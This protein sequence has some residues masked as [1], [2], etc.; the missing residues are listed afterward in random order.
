[1]IAVAPRW[2]GRVA[3]AA[4]LLAVACGVGAAIAVPVVGAY[5][6]YDESIESLRHQHRKL[7][8]V[9]ATQASL[10]RQLARIEAQR[11]GDEYMLTGDSEALAG[12]E[13]QNL[14]KELVVRNGG[15]LD[16]TQVLEAQTEGVLE[17]ITIRARFST[18]VPSLKRTL[19]VFEAGKPALFVERIEIR[20]DTAAARQVVGGAARGMPLKVSMD[21][22]GYRP[23][24]GG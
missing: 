14:A 16:S 17:R 3:A 23:K 18:T 22:F 15:K 9:A 20:A 21:V 7:S 6:R 2:L 1:M 13:L 24:G 4:L 12:A 19:Y 5:A 8:E 11:P 10:Q